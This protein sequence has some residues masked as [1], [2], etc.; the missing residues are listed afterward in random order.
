MRAFYF[1]IFRFNNVPSKN[2]TNVSIIVIFRIYVSCSRQLKRL[3][4]VTRSPI[5]SHFGETVTGAATIRAY[6][7]Q[8]TIAFYAFSTWPDYFTST[9][10]KRTNNKICQYYFTA[11]FHY[12]RN[13]AKYRK[14]NCNLIAIDFKTVFKTV[15]RTSSSGSLSWS[16]TR[17]RRLTSH[18][19]LQIG[20]SQFAWKLS[21]IWYAKSAFNL[22]YL[23]C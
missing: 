14:Y 6:N 2:A 5:Y 13:S 9:M 19:S 21:E 17:I 3:E 7:L 11:S 22:I 16:S 12:T 18:P 4:S 23:L 1:L 8:V 10:K 20:G 15:F